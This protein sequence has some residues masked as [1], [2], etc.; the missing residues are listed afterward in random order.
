LRRLTLVSSLIVLAGVAS[1]QSDAPPSPAPTEYEV[2]A[3]FL[4]NFTQF[5]E[6]PAEPAPAP[7][8]PFLIAVLG[9]DP[10]GAT[11]DRAVAGKTV[12]GRRI[13]I[14]RVSR[15]DEVAGSEIVFIC[16]S[17]RPSLP[18]LLKAL[19]PSG[20]LT[21]GETD[22]F[23]AQGGMINFVRQGRQVRFEINPAAAEQA[24]LKVSSQL[25]KLAILVGG[26]AD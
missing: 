25:L 13:A 17:E 9:R 23:A 11:L 24:G 26:G 14:R 7:D 15:A 16:A 19:P 20:L 10:F 4:Y 2:K 22:G 6:W 8:A 21:V 5:V 1:A 12:S 18:A 3:G